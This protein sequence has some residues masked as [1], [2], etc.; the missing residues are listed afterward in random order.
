MTE[1]R[2][3]IR[4]YRPG[5][6]EAINR[7]F[8]QVF[9]RDRELAEWAWKFPVDPVGRCIMV[10]ER[11][12]EILTQ[13]A[14]TVVRFQIDDRLWMT[15]HIV[16]AFATREARRSLN[17]QGLWIRTVE[18][19][20]DEFS[21]SGLVPLQFGFPGRR[22]RRLGILQLGYDAMEPQPVKYLVRRPGT[23]RSGRRR[24]LYR[25]EIGRDWEPRLD[26]LWAR[27]SSQYP[28]A[29]VRDA[30]HGLRR[31]AGHPRVRYHRFLVFPRLS[32]EPVALVI[33]RSDQQRLRW[34]DF[35]WDHDHPG[36]LELAAHL[37]GELAAR[38]GCLV[39][40]MWINGDP[41][42]QAR[43]ERL[44]FEMEPE[45]QGLEMCAKAF[46]DEADL[47][48]MGERVYITMGDSDLA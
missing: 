42:G 28:V 12:G 13:Y 45:P 11:G 44:G 36:A 6:E 19:F 43:L 29:V 38:A 25:A 4:A 26:R 35:L 31:F 2:T 46:D 17:R 18:R 32:S 27:V 34:A 21:R 39:E 47:K 3:Q 10:A 33:F 16:D 9:R 22:H 41:A 7:A 37:S 8:N 14:A 23:A 5:D 40:E 1:A 30:D 15:N 24:L 20:Y 48:A